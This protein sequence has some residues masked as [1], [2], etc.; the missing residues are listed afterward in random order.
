[1]THTL[2]NVRIKRALELSNRRPAL[3]LRTLRALLRS[4]ESS[5]KTA[6]GDWHHAQTLHMLSLVQAA[7]GDRRGSGETLMRL[8]DQHEA[9]MKY[10]MRAY[11]SACAAAA[12]Q[13]ALDRKLVRA[14]QM[15][16]RANRWSRS[17]EPED[18]LLAQARKTIR[19]L[20]VKTR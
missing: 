20:S 4:V 7:A 16:Q 8:A 14:K 18:E 19:A 1:M 12:L 17:L 11:V 3:A 10:E 5:R 13:L 15:L 6:L 9:Q 2:W